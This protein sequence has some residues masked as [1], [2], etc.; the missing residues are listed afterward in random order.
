VE[1]TDNPERLGLSASHY[2]TAGLHHLAYRS[3]GSA[4]LDRCPAVHARSSHGTLYS[5]EPGFRV[6]W[7]LLLVT[8]PCRSQ[9]SAMCI[10]WRPTTI[11]CQKHTR[12]SDN[13]SSRAP[14]SRMQKHVMHLICAN[15][16]LFRLQS[17]DDPP[18]G[19]PVANHVFVCDGQQ[20]TLF[21][22]QDFLLGFCH[23]LHE[24]RHFCEHNMSDSN[25]RPCS[26]TVA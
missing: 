19:A 3:A 16:L 17:L 22:G 24:L 20:V 26:D 13:R 2:T 8:S 11:S 18:G 21:H 9:P 12:Q 23:L 7:L 10:A 6:A 15:L 4:L 1:Q 25:I 14:R 5:S